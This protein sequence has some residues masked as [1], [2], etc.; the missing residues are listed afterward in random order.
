VLA[1]VNVTCVAGL[2]QGGSLLQYSWLL[3]ANVI[4]RALAGRHQSE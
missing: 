2:Q 3:Q 1:R 4:P